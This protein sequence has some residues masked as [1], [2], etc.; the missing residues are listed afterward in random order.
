[1]LTITACKK[2]LNKKGIE[3]TDEQIEIIR[4]VLYTLA[5]IHC[6]QQEK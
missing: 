3:Y 2:L 1:M 6:Q 4:N 5:E